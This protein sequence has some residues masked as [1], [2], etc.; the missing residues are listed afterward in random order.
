MRRLFR[1]PPGSGLGGRRDR[2]RRAANT[3]GF[4]ACAAAMAF[5][6]YVQYVERIE[7]CHLC[8]VQRLCV[9]ALGGVFALAA[10]HDPRRGG[11]R[12]Y[13]V[14]LAVVALAG[15]VFAG[16]H[17]WVQHQPAGSVGSCG[18]SLELM[19][20]MLPPSEVLA[21]VFRGGEECQRIDW[22]LLG[23][24]M[25]AWVFVLFLVLGAA[26]AYVNF[27]RPRAA[28]RF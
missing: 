26:G 20:Q 1:D 14:L 10:L 17:V 8:T 5:A 11:S 16:R 21:R 19:L 18:A 13:A 3:A 24:S 12:V 6:L 9:I 4:A 25:P 15:M 22:T 7:P 27:R 23:L 2:G 28:F